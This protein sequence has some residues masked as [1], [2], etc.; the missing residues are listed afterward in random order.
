MKHVVQHPLTK[1][2]AKRAVEAAWAS[3]SQRLTKYEPKLQWLDED[4]AR[5]DFTMRGRHFQGTFR[6]ADRSLELELDVPLLLRPFV[7]PA[8]LAIDREVDKWVKHVQ[9]QP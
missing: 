4:R 6:I 3:Y 8:T 9:S 2:D 1:A 5:V 7:K